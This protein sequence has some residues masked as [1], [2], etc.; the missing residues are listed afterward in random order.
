MGRSRLKHK[1]GWK[2]EARKRAGLEAAKHVED[3]FVIGLGSGNTAAYAIE[4]VAK[5]VKQQ[6]LKIL[7]VP[8]SS[9][10]M[11]L[12]VE[13]GIPLTTLD[14]H[15]RMDLTVDG[16]DQIDGALN[17][18]KGMGGALARE[19]IVASA[20]KELIIVADETKLTVRL[21]TNQ[22]L[23]VEVLP[24]AASTIMSRIREMGGKPVLRKGSGKVGPIV[25]DNGN[26]VVDADFGPIDDPHKLNLHVKMIPGV[27]ETGLFVEMA[28]IVYVG[29]S[30][31]VQKMEREQGSG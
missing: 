15:A 11:L 31:S 22:L 14:E 21:G 23:P 20:S 27:I 28:D 13:C 5:R 26:Y 10:A 30:N 25:T 19:K 24:F 16:A 8:T 29:K 2:E 3:G 4:E 17:L 9:Q 7:G 18:I 12:A 1:M 6:G